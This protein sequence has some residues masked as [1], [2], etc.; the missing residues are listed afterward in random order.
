MTFILSTFLLINLINVVINLYKKNFVLFL[1][2]V[3]F[4][5]L[6]GLQS[7]WSY[8]KL[9]DYYQ[10]V[11]GYNLINIHSHSQALYYFLLF[12]IMM[13]FLSLICPRYSV[14]KWK[15]TNKTFLSKNYILF[16]NVFLFLLFIIIIY[17]MTLNAGGVINFLTNPGSLISG[18]TSLLLLTSIFK[19]PLFARIILNIHINIGS[20]FF[21]IIYLIIA[22]FNSRFLTIFAIFQM[23]IF[24]HYFKSSFPIKKLINVFLLVLAVVFL[25]GGYRHISHANSDNLTF[26]EYYDQL[27]LFSDILVEWFFT[28]NT[29]VFSGLSDVLNRKNSLVDDFLLPELNSFVNLFPS[30]VKNDVNF[31]IYDFQK[32][33]SDNSNIS[34]SVVPS[35]FEIYTAS[36]GFFGFLFY[37][38]VLI[39]FIYFIEYNFCKHK[40]SFTNIISIQ[41]LNG[42]RGSLFSSI[43][44][45]GLVD[46]LFFY[47]Y[48]FF[49]R[50]R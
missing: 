45:F 38:M 40:N 39:S 5:V 28:L 19:W 2:N 24:L 31:Y 1:F 16:E 33:I 14:S 35:G 3:A 44:F 18:Q 7:F 20:V 6:C 25:F 36:F 30:F 17:L 32:Y 42:L 4:F 41:S 34:N 48:K 10:F 27:I 15:Y 26:K 46:L 8:Y 49:Y 21:F 43:C 11:A 22:V 50:K 29:E 9:I 23:I 47:F 37:S 13:L 12:Q